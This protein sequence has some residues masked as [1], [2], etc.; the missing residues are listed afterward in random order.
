MARYQDALRVLLDAPEVDALLFMHAP[1]AIV[2]SAN[3]AAACLPMMQKTDKL[4][5]TS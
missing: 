2:S 4:I 1:T 3:I 5:L